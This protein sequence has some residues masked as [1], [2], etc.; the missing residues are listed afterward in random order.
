MPKK[1]DDFHTLYSL[2]APKWK[3]CRDFISGADALRDYDIG[4]DGSASDCYLPRLSPRQ[5]R[6]EYAAY[7]RRALYYNA[8]GRTHGGFLGLIIGR[9]ADVDIPAAA[10]PLRAD[11]DLGG[12]PLEEMIETTVSEVLEANRY[13]WLIDHPTLSEEEKA[14]KTRLDVEREGLR[15]YIV[16]YKAEDIVNWERARIG[17]VTKTVRVVL[18]EAYI[19]ADGKDGARYRELVL[20]A[21]IYRIREWEKVGEKG[22]EEYTLTRETTP[23]MN[24]AP[25]SEI[26]FFFFDAHGG[27]TDP[28]RPTLLDL[29]EVNRSHYQSSAD[30]EHA[31]FACSVPTPYFIGF[32]A[33]DAKSIVLGGLNGIHATDSSAKV[34]FL[35][36]TGQGTEPLER[37]LTQKEAMMAKLGSR[38]L[39]EDKRDA[40]TAETM[41]IRSSGESATLADVARSIGRVAGQALTL[42]AAWFGGS[43]DAVVTLNTEYTTATASPQE[44]TALLASV[45]AGELPSRDFVDRLRK[46]G[47]I[48]PERTDE[49]IEADLEVQ[50]ERKA[51]AQGSG[52]LAAAAALRASGAAA[53]G[54]AA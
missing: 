36:Y 45:Q 29:V 38:M 32:S 53:A 23:L 50:R 48:S 4:R 54:G 1:I 43:G 37:A 14:Q 40:E 35:E 3:R 11:A 52:L 34:G 28:Q 12:M 21:G 16:G 33:E 24:N 30:L 27:R 44:I 7:V 18:R 26:P 42:A 5:T 9:G 31:R 47:V 46:V 19:A 20:E 49:D 8:V 2:T 15:P 41:R 10:E 39:A 13:G 6:E 22:K 25:L 51:A 17:A